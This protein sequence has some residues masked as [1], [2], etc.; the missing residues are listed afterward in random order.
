MQ[1]LVSHHQFVA[2]T[3]GDEYER[4]KESSPITVN[5]KKSAA[6]REVAALRTTIHGKERN[7]AGLVSIHVKAIAIVRNNVAKLR[8]Q[9]KVLQA[10]SNA[11]K[12]KI[13]LIEVLIDI[14]QKK[15]EMV[16]FADTTEK[17]NEMLLI[18]LP[19]EIDAAKQK[20]KDKFTATTPTPLVLATDSF[21]QLKQNIQTKNLSIFTKS[22]RVG[23]LHPLLSGKLTM[24]ETRILEV[25]K[26]KAGIAKAEALQIEVNEILFVR[27]DERVFNYV[28]DEDHYEDVLVELEELKKTLVTETKELNGQYLDALAH[29]EKYNDDQRY[30]LWA[31]TEVE[32]EMRKSSGPRPSVANS[33]AIEIV[34]GFL[35]EFE[36][37]LKEKL[38]TP[39][40]EMA[41]QNRQEGMVDMEELAKRLMDEMKEL[42]W[43][44]LA[45]ADE[46]E[47]Q[48]TQIRGDVDVAEM[49]AAF[50]ARFETDFPTTNLE[51]FVNSLVFRDLK[52]VKLTS[53]QNEFGEANLRTIEGNVNLALEEAR[54]QNNLD[55]L[56][57]I[58]LVRER[59]GTFAKTYQRLKTN[60]IE[61]SLKCVRDFSMI[62]SKEFDLK[63]SIHE[64]QEKFEEY[65]QIREH[66]DLVAKMVKIGNAR[67][68]EKIRYDTFKTEF[69]KDVA[70][71]KKKA[72]KFPTDSR[73]RKMAHY[74]SDQFDFEVASAFHECMNDLNAS[75]IAESTFTFDSAKLK[76]NDLVTKFE[77]EMKRMEEF[78][79]E[80]IACKR[81][82]ERRIHPSHLAAARDEISNRLRSF[83][84]S[85]KDTSIYTKKHNNIVTNFEVVV[86][87]WDEAVFAAK[88]EGVGVPSLSI[89]KGYF[90]ILRDETA[91]LVF[92]TREA[93]KRRE[94]REQE[95]VARLEH[96]KAEKDKHDAWLKKVQDV[97]VLDILEI[98][99]DMLDMEWVKDMIEEVETEKLDYEKRRNDRMSSGEIVAKLKE[100]HKKHIE[101]VQAFKVARENFLKIANDFAAYVHA[102]KIYQI[103]NNTLNDSTK[104]K[105]ELWEKC[106][107]EMIALQ[108]FATFKIQYSPVKGIDFKIVHI[109]K[110]AFASLV[111][112]AL[113]VNPFGGKTGDKNLDAQI[114]AKRSEISA[115]AF[116]ADR[117]TLTIEMFTH[118][119]KIAHAI[120][121]AQGEME[122]TD[123]EARTRMFQYLAKIGIFPKVFNSTTLEPEDQIYFDRLILG[124]A[125]PIPNPTLDYYEKMSK[126]ATSTRSK[127]LVASVNAKLELIK[128]KIKSN[129]PDSVKNIIAE[130]KVLTEKANEPFVLDTPPTPEE[131]KHAFDVFTALANVRSPNDIGG[132]LGKLGL[133]N[134]APRLAKL[135]DES[136]DDFQT[137]C[138]RMF[139][140]RLV[141]LKRLSEIAPS[142]QHSQ[143]EALLTI[144]TNTLET[145]YNGSVVW[146]A[147][148]AHALGKELGVDVELHIDMFK[149]K[150]R[151]DV[152]RLKGGRLKMLTNAKEACKKEVDERF[153]QFKERKDD[154]LVREQ[155]VALLMSQTIAIIKNKEEE[156]KQ[157]IGEMDRGVGGFFDTMR[158]SSFDQLEK[159]VINT[160]IEIDAEIIKKDI[161]EMF[162]GVQ[163]D[164]TIIVGGRTFELSNMENI[165]ELMDR[166]KRR[167]VVDVEG[168]KLFE[169]EVGLLKKELELQQKKIEDNKHMV[170][171]LALIDQKLE[172]R[173]TEAKREVMKYISSVMDRSQATALGMV[174]SKYLK[175]TPLPRKIFD[176]LI[177]KRVDDYL[178]KFEEQKKREQRVLNASIELEQKSMELQAKVKE[179]VSVK[180]LDSKLFNID[181]VANVL[182]FM[183][184]TSS[185]SL[186]A[187][188]ERTS[189]LITKLTTL[190]AIQK[191]QLGALVV[192]WDVSKEI[193]RV[194]SEIED[195]SKVLAK[196]T[197]VLSTLLPTRTDFAGEDELTD[198]SF[199]DRAYEWQQMSMG[200]IGSIF[201]EI[202]AQLEVEDDIRLYIVETFQNNLT[203]KIQTSM[204]QFQDTTTLA[205]V[206]ASVHAFVEFA[207]E[208][209]EAITTSEARLELLV[210]SVSK[211]TGWAD[212]TNL[213]KNGQTVIQAQINEL[214][215]TLDKPNVKPEETDAMLRYLFGTIS[216]WRGGD[217]VN[218]VLKYEDVRA[219]VQ[220]E[221]GD[222]FLKLE[223]M[224]LE[225]K[226]AE[227][228]NAASGILN[229]ASVFFGKTKVVDMTGFMVDV[230]RPF[231]TTT[232][233]IY[234]FPISLNKEVWI[235]RAKIDEP[236]TDDVFLIVRDTLF[237]LDWAAKVIP[238]KTK[239]NLDNHLKSKK[240]SHHE[241]TYA[242]TE[243]HGRKLEIVAHESSNIYTRR[244]AAINVDVKFKDAA[245]SATTEDLLSMPSLFLF[246][247]CFT[248][249]NTM[250]PIEFAS[251]NNHCPW[252]EAKERYFGFNGQMSKNIH[253]KDGPSQ[254]S[255]LQPHEREMMK[256]SFPVITHAIEELTGAIS[257]LFSESNFPLCDDRIF[258]FHNIHLTIKGNPSSDERTLWGRF[259]EEFLILEGVN[260]A[261]KRYIGNFWEA[262]R[263][264]TGIL[265][266]VVN[267][268][269][270]LESEIMDSL[271]VLFLN[272]YLKKDKTREQARVVR[273]IFRTYANQLES[274]TKFSTLS[275]TDLAQKAQE[276]LKKVNVDP[277][278]QM[279]RQPISDDI[280][281]NVVIEVWQRQ[282]EE[283]EKSEFVSLYAQ[284]SDTVARATNA[285]N[286]Y[287]FAAAFALD[288]SYNEVAT[289]F[290]DA[291]LNIPRIKLEHESVKRAHVFFDVLP[292][293]VMA[294]LR[295]NQIERSEDV[296]NKTSTHAQ[297]LMLLDLKKKEVHVREMVM[298]VDEM[299]GEET[300]VL[301]ATSADDE[302]MNV[303]LV[304]RAIVISRGID[305]TR[306]VDT[307]TFSSFTRD[308]LT[309]T[310]DFLKMNLNIENEKGSFRVEEI[311][312]DICKQ[313]G[314]EIFKSVI[315]PKSKMR[316]L[317]ESKKCALVNGEEVGMI[318]M[319][320]HFLAQRI[321]QAKHTFRG[322]IFKRVDRNTGIYLLANALFYSTLYLST[323]VFEN[324][325]NLTPYQNVFVD[326]GIV[327]DRAENIMS[328]IGRITLKI[329]REGIP[330]FTSRQDVATYFTT[331]IFTATPKEPKR[332]PKRVAVEYGYATVVETPENLLPQHLYVAIKDSRQL[333][334]EQPDAY[335]KKL[336]EGI[337]VP[338]VFASSSLKRADVVENG[339]SKYVRVHTELFTLQGGQPD[340][341][342]AGTPEAK[343]LDFV[344]KD[345]DNSITQ[346]EEDK[347]RFDEIL[348]N[349]IIHT[350]ED[351]KNVNDIL[352]SPSSLIEHIFQASTGSLLI[353]PTRF[354]A[355]LCV[356]EVVFGVQG[357][358]GTWTITP[359]SEV[360]YSIN[361]QKQNQETLAKSIH[362]V[363]KVCLDF[364]KPG[365]K[366]CSDGL[367]A[368][369]VESAMPWLWVARGE[370][371]L[372]FDKFVTEW[373]TMHWPNSSIIWRAFR[374][375]TGFLRI[376][377]DDDS[378]LLNILSIH[379]LHLFIT[380]LSPEELGE[381][382][383]EMRDKIDELVEPQKYLV[384]KR[385]I[386]DL[387][388]EL[389][390]VNIDTVG[391]VIEDKSTFFEIANELVNPDLPFDERI[392]VKKI[393]PLGVTHLKLTKDNIA[394]FNSLD[395]VIS[396][397]L[398]L[399]S[400]IHILT[401]DQALRN[402]PNLANSFLI[403][404]KTNPPFVET[405]NS[406]KT[407][408]LIS[409]T[410]NLNGSNQRGIVS[411]RT[412]RP[413]ESEGYMSGDY[414]DDVRKIVNGLL[415]TTPKFIKRLLWGTRTPK[416]LETVQGNMLVHN[417]MRNRKSGNFKISVERSVCE[418]WESFGFLWH[419]CRKV[420]S[421]LSFEWK[422]MPMFLFDAAVIVYLCKVE[423]EKKDVD[424]F[425]DLLDRVQTSYD[426]AIKSK[427]VFS[428]DL[429]TFKRKKM[430][431]ID[432]EE[433]VRRDELITESKTEIRHLKVE[434]QHLHERMTKIEGYHRDLVKV[435]ATG[436][437]QKEAQ[438]E[439]TRME[440][441][442]KHIA[443]DINS[444][445]L[446]IHN[447]EE[448]ITMHGEGVAESAKS[449]I[450]S[451]L[452]HPPT[453]SI[454]PSP[455]TKSKLSIPSSSPS[456]LPTPDPSPS[457]KPSP[458][459][460]TT[461]KPSPKPSPPSTSIPNPSPP[462]TSTPPSPS[463]ST[464]PTPSTPPSTPSTPPI[465]T[466]DPLT[467][468]PPPNSND[469]FY[470]GNH[471]ADII[472]D[473]N[474]KTKLDAKLPWGILKEPSIKIAMF[475]GYPSEWDIENVHHSTFNGGNIY[476]VTLDVQT[477]RDVKSEAYKGS[478]VLSTKGKV[479]EDTPQNTETIKT[480]ATLKTKPIESVIQV[481]LSPDSL[482]KTDIMSFSAIPKETGTKL[483]VATS[484]P[485][486]DKVLDQV[487]KITGIEVER[488]E[489]GKVEN[490]VCVYFKFMASR[491]NHLAA[492]CA[493]IF[494]TR[495][496]YVVVVAIGGAIPI[497]RNLKTKDKET[498]KS[499]MPLRIRFGGDGVLLET[500]ED[501]N[502]Q[503]IRTMMSI[504]HLYSK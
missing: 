80:V 404:N 370:P 44:K 100:V 203:Q 50:K 358:M 128:E 69:N 394:K 53:I 499:L 124:K 231:S 314:R 433:R 161:G 324:W 277:R 313:L 74:L 65:V 20:F 138:K 315:Q 501:V 48:M 495:E 165:H 308:N 173:P 496:V 39:I 266:G 181:K 319:R 478:F 484:N 72:I 454:P 116:T 221:Q 406:V 154:L 125:N 441:D 15:L 317:M 22:E 4:T 322:F 40:E 155:D 186:P 61:V 407:G 126:M 71:R 13:D 178:T 37:H 132:L 146:F 182:G 472:D 250:L 170:D 254:L 197:T 169:A 259:A 57:R 409:V 429:E 482:V 150:M 167:H 396:P 79:L 171:E 189:Q 350:E 98:T 347:K 183:D 481:V 236:S 377:K 389:G 419:T 321:W 66:L 5:E 217:G 84:V 431:V 245:N 30:I 444:K 58:S 105:F 269:H 477:P 59:V 344:Y 229:K 357:I 437:R 320:A 356:L 92:N 157:K 112:T 296:F 422:K 103:T 27:G 436:F 430:V 443:E 238:L 115:I 272:T 130:V 7:Q 2:Q 243:L 232:N 235:S 400:L 187:K 413:D 364:I 192:D 67:K 274:M 276:L 93:I 45:V 331:K 393:E 210:R 327:G 387:S 83:F 176:T 109:D 220:Y 390:R 372:D 493:K 257:A 216:S 383:T 497:D 202:K 453:P 133:A 278:L 415:E 460:S 94:K 233:P 16:L 206:E 35:V 376:Y 374:K 411:G 359:P 333:L 476:L 90:D 97:K 286:D 193:E 469:V 241:K 345:Y 340:E 384:T 301:A 131:E 46:L 473:L 224:R 412:V 448:N 398:F 310:D 219:R 29:P 9:R 264:A 28:I 160:K 299:I 244:D 51:R 63:A 311:N 258:T 458:K 191:N 318:A 256:L 177:V 395:H 486:C 426:M 304:N 251:W 162:D 363:S 382:K 381:L 339:R 297:S 228:T 439:L 118:A 463:P 262:V 218:K 349:P 432:E 421:F 196:A 18:Q 96:E 68:V 19:A 285:I 198:Q 212:I 369:A 164:N 289:F 446:L 73:V 123:T 408:N 240:Y 435:M 145:A 43:S 342:L 480:L 6:Y 442:H 425:Y 55:D 211:I 405:L 261:F 388:E 87:A 375:A 498:I 215:F 288:Y 302:V 91:N 307:N 25:I 248:G 174:E 64:C 456:S 335:K 242:Y 201:N 352:A 23:K 166:L 334:D 410:W 373:F 474:R 24:L 305:T 316:L 114:D 362:A 471:V 287:L 346:T 451:D 459:P 85:G 152:D 121:A 325:A 281:R 140:E 252:A 163:K 149:Q 168:R 329:L 265:G 449:H 467:H 487:V 249:L 102:L 122:N 207:R 385:G 283:G 26:I 438:D 291:N 489:S 490:G 468:T 253:K 86:R 33:K 136:V 465:F 41:T 440:A 77:M 336:L 326:V 417:A 368:L 21:D 462:S 391:E 208:T 185:L 290:L 158:E 386:V 263:S 502:R 81:D 8:E 226:M 209:W 127:E 104:A 14:F 423:R 416:Q 107:L 111:T 82:M 10:T 49:I 485:I 380:R 225:S 267:H 76:I 292:F 70:M 134:E 31:K 268:S 147:H 56:R 110:L 17:I 293:Q 348:T 38:I 3:V 95:E 213:A 295:E 11:S 184:A 88:A 401:T 62:N 279:A 461:P 113:F 420:F 338:L 142:E 47:F 1:E 99:P 156:I 270:G 255:H 303:A 129:E 457:P 153:K 119:L 445:L 89:R 332:P 222:A 300:V 143:I 455:S 397:H 101:T 343:F 237:G 190:T 141:R 464:P 200:M 488:V 247:S 392:D 500:P 137:E 205:N 466:Y 179:M 78:D 180:F 12:V 234:A 52:F 151:N 172:S 379:M 246:V 365:C 34:T 260:H 351:K 273:N 42:V 204:T 239:T 195:H 402:V 492:D 361:E 227:A 371:K 418:N 282:F 139:D 434:I 271:T 503:N 135:F 32:R 354:D 144:N 36:N 312:V 428:R 337:N 341:E 475:R 280:L 479:I 284:Q 360:T 483:L 106:I 378:Q 504:Q 366:F 108:D 330:N 230:E 309:F 159:Y 450:A 403:Y 194:S 424:E 355:L 323:N 491:N 427:L 175:R 399:C 494:G 470:Y 117:G 60:V 367:F 214:I 275:K 447:Y 306:N 54:L 120:K 223:R 298:D 328:F 414:K 188:I 75:I 353:N 452:S 294:C 148:Q 199:K